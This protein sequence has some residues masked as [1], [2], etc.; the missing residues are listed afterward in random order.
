MTESKEPVICEDDTDAVFAMLASSQEKIELTPTQWM[1]YLWP[2]LRKVA[3]VS[4]LPPIVP[5]LTERTWYRLNDGDNSVY[6]AITEKYLAQLR[7]GKQC[8]RI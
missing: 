3:E 2:G 8:V 1:N 5:G 4:E 7:A 6:P